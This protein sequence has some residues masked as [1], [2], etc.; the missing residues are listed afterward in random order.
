MATFEGLL[1]LAADR[2]KKVLALLT[3]DRQLAGRQDDTGYSLLHASAS[4]GHSELLR[5]LVTDFAVDVNLVD[6]DHETCLF[7]VESEEIAMCLVEEL[8]I[9]MAIENS[10]GQTALMKLQEEGDTPEVVRYLR[11]RSKGQSVEDVVRIETPLKIPVTMTYMSA[12]EMPG[13][14]SVDDAFRRRID[15]LI[16]H[17][18]LQTEHGQ[19]AFEQLVTDVVKSHIVDSDHND[20]LRRAS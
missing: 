17:G 13:G 6:E 14:E 18:D 8:G 2:P 9:N 10:E 15:D 1:I 19:Q 7:V 16:E 20:R 3:G 11:T 12:A 5:A 4:Y